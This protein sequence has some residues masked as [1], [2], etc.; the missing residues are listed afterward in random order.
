MAVHVDLVNSPYAQPP[1]APHPPSH[2]GKKI[3]QENKRQIEES[4]RLQEFGQA[5]KESWITRLYTHVGM[6][7]STDKSAPDKSSDQGKD[8]AWA[9]KSSVRSGER[10]ANSD[11]HGLRSP[12]Q[13]QLPPLPKS[14]RHPHHKT[15]RSREYHSIINREKTCIITRPSTAGSIPKNTDPI[16]KKTSSKSKDKHL[17]VLPPELASSPYLPDKERPNYKILVN[18][19]I[20]E[21]ARVKKAFYQSRAGSGR[22]DRSEHRTREQQS[23]LIR[24]NTYVS[25]YSQY[26]SYNR[27]GDSTWRHALQKAHS[28]AELEK[29]AKESADKAMRVSA[30]PCKVCHSDSTLFFPHLETQRSLHSRIQSA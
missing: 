30:R 9:H 24:R 22:R 12:K 15:Q 13:G 29:K 3:I 25:A 7:K 26:G 27:S 19:R 2:P 5:S 10:S 20:K 11:D 21:L 14:S 1:I 23:W 8:D 4:K 16:V 18:E 28:S 6:G 17:K